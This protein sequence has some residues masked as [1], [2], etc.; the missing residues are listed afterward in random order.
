MKEAVAIVGMAC[1]YPDACSPVE[2]W[3]NALAQRRAFRR[4]PSERLRL[5]DYLSSDKSKPDHIYSSEAAVIEGYEFDRLRFRVSGSAF[6]SADMAHWL[7]LDVA[8]QSL[9]DAGFPD[10]E[11][12]DKQATGIFLG[13][14]LTGE[15]SRANS[16]R[17]RWPYVRRVLESVLVERSFSP[18][19]IRDCMERC[20]Q[21]YKDPFPAVGEDTLAGNLSNTIAGRICN[22]F[23]FKGAGYVVDGACAS[24]LLA[25]ATAC[26]AL[27]AGDLDVALAGGVDLSIDPFELV[28][29]AKAGALATGSFR[30]YDAR[31]SGFLPGEGCGFV[32]LMRHSDAI[33]MKC[34][35]Y[36]VIKGWGI[37]TD[38]RGAITRPETEGQLLAFERAY[39]RAAFGADSVGYFEG[40]GTGTSLGDSTEIE[41]IL[42][43]RRSASAVARIGSIKA[44]IGHTKAAAGIAG[45]IKATLAVHKQVLPPTTACDIPHPKLTATDAK[46]KTSKHGEIWPAELPLRASVSAMG[47]G[48]INAHITLEGAATQRRSELD[49]SERALL[50]TAQDAELFLMAAND[51]QRLLDQVRHLLTFASRI[52]MAEM[53]DLAATMQETLDANVNASDAFRAAIVAS[54]PAELASRLEALERELASGV[55]QEIDVDG[56]VFVGSNRKAQIGFFFPGQASPVYLDGGAFSRR[57]DFVREFYRKTDFPLTGNTAATEI[58][59]PAIIAASLAGLRVMER[60]GIK[61]DV[62][63]GHSLGE[64]TALHWAGSFD[65]EGA[66]R[67]AAARASAM[68]NSGSLPGGMASIKGDQYEVEAML[69]GDPIVIACLNSPNQ[70]VVSGA[71]AAVQNF[72]ALARSRGS[73]VVMLNVSHAFHSPL[74]ASAI[75]L[76]ADYLSLENFQAPS[77]KAFSTVTAAPIS[78][79]ANLREL[80]FQQ[81]TSPVRFFEAAKAAAADADLFIEIGPGHVLT[82]LASEFLNKPVVSID[83]GG[84]SLKGLLNALGAVYVLGAVTDYASLFSDRITKPFNLDWQPRFFINPCELAPLI[85]GEARYERAAEVSV[86]EDHEDSRKALLRIKQ[87][88]GEAKTTLELIRNLVA[89]RAEL[90]PSAV[91]ENDRL[92]GD[93]HLNSITVGQIVAET[94]NHLGTGVPF[95]PTDYSTVTLAEIA[96]AFDEGML[97]GNL[98]SKAR[99]IPVGVDSWTRCFEIRYIEQPLPRQKTSSVESDWQVICAPNFQLAENLKEEFAKCEGSGVVIALPPDCDENHIGILLEGARAAMDRGDGSKFVLVEQGK[100]AAAFARTFHLE[101]PWITTCVA[102]IPINHPQ[103]IKWVAEEAKAAI[104][105]TEARYDVSGKRSA[106]TLKLLP[107]SDEGEIPLGKDDVMLVTG[108]GKGIAAECAI[109]VA[110]DT[111]MRLVLLGRSDPTG[112][113]ELKANLERMSSLGIRFRYFA[114][115]VTDIT[116]IAEAVKRAEI[117]V[118]PITALLHAAGA[119]TPKLLETLDEKTF[120]ETLR[121]KIEGARNVLRSIRPERLK[122]FITFGSLIARAGMRGEADYALANQ[123]LTSLT[124][125]WQAQH[126]RCRCLAIEWSVWAGAGMGQRLG[127]VDSL[128]EQGIT[129]I[130][131]DEGVRVFKHLLA[132]KSDRVAVVVSGRFG[133]SPALKIEQPDLP[134]LR[135]LEQP[136]LYY[137]GIEIIVESE[138]SNQTDPYLEDHVLDGDEIFPAVMGLEAMAQV[139][140]VLAETDEPPV[141]ESVRFNRAIVVPAASSTTIAIAAL[142]RGPGVVEVVLRGKLTDFQVD[143]FR[144]L[145]R[146]GENVAP[147]EL[148]EPDAQITEATTELPFIAIRPETDLYGE[149]LFQKGRF[150][151]VRGYR[152]IASTGCVAEI[153]ETQSKWFGPYLPRALVL[154]DPGRRDATIHAVQVCVPDVTLLPISIDELVIEKTSADGPKTLRACER[155]RVGDIFTYD[156]ELRDRKGALVETWKNLRLQMVNTKRSQHNLSAPLLGA[157][158]ERIIREIVPGSRVSVALESSAGDDRR[159]ASDK[160]IHRALGR[161]AQILRRPDGKPEIDADLQISA[162]HS[163]NLTLAVAGASK[164]GCDLEAVTSRAPSIWKGLLG[165]EH[166]KLAELIAR[167]ANNDAHAAATRVWTAIECLKKTDAAVDAPLTFDSI[168]GDDCVLLASG[169]RVI[170]TFQLSIKEAQGPHILAILLSAQEAGYQTA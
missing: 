57:F 40:H 10:A 31:S 7:A 96:R 104:G 61:A 18:E 22:H 83:A 60:F 108:G 42:R 4:I 16:M 90:P 19:Q 144:A 74:L 112:D 165:E 153:E 100:G 58:A 124:E 130:P 101:S 45:L 39:K 125:D 129:P 103:A 77:R 12:L 81:M 63:V 5:E 92:L 119:N 134:F 1:R 55:S 107:E 133:Q 44:N 80:L 26:S 13:N 115:D 163:G 131:L 23:D 76:L 99:R 136:K 36:A 85:E 98:A 35:I 87:N 94:A 114:A 27:V 29:F 78:S 69:N 37:S 75:P 160:A 122:A 166:Y 156:L 143:H 53:T 128:I 116:Q 33:E 59:Q 9:I 91:T 3:E 56:G 65:E 70:T 66:I 17:L 113:A 102:N 120:L 109:S 170:A 118:G 30:V 135:F 54:N 15:F 150:E 140:M 167:E 84:D 111:G 51:R 158:I 67:I 137:P 159:S 48:G 123:W 68:N 62:A 126:P 127:T 148:L 21:V 154:G 24:S 43:A 168:R 121:P 49:S 14:T 64:V 34:R 8:S 139:A 151:R 110:R 2:L 25:V 72:V 157:Y 52:S 149:I 6:R 132:R 162:S 142:K 155:S 93:L 47:F 164:V 11:G 138:L 105:Y 46:L 89:A 141:F 95:A 97:A 28:G 50:R 32:V 147:S 71:A 41:T 106:P 88:A 86:R 79:S 146:F 73:A 152:K 117:E 20:E 145:C 161:D 169:A 38:G 82:G